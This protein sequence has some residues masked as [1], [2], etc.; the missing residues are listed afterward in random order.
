MVKKKLNAVD[1]CAPGILAIR[2]VVIFLNTLVL[3]PFSL[4]GAP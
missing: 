2:L 4:H 3:F 1:F